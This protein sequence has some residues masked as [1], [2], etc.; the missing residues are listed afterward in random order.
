MLRRFAG[1]ARDRPGTAQEW[2]R[3]ARRRLKADLVSPLEQRARVAQLFH[4]LS[5]WK[6][7]YRIISA[8]T[9]DTNLLHACLHFH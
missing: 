5:L 8:F 2:P 7:R 9:S 1:W 6:T 4:E 3:K